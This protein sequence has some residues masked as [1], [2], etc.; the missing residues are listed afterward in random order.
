LSI[1]QRYLQACGTS[2]LRLIETRMTA[3][4]ILTASGW[5]A[6]NS[7]KRAMALQ[8]YSVL[9]TENM[10]GAQAVAAEL[11]K[12]I[13]RKS[14]EDYRAAMK[15]VEAHDLALMV[16]KWWKRPACLTCGG[17]GHPTMPGSPVLDESK[18][19]QVCHGTGLI[20]LE[21]LMKAEHIPYANWLISEMDSI[22]SSVFD[23]IARRLRDF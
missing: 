13:R 22:T 17:H 23:A 19:C 7:A 8:I 5:V 9:A 4:D 20:P 15:T 10:R 16:L 1:Q 11:A 21:R 6:S 18:E 14:F 12:W 3:A 2:R